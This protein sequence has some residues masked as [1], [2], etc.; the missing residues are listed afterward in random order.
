MFSESIAHLVQ[1]ISAAV[2]PWLVCCAAVS[3]V[4]WLISLRF[5]KSLFARPIA[6]FYD[7]S[8]MKE[9]SLVCVVLAFVFTVVPKNDRGMGG[10]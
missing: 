7:L 6:R 4:L 10:N 5:W 9:V 8:L 3:A 2:T 1:K